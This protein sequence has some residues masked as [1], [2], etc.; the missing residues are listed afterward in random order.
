MHACMGRK[1]DF[2]GVSPIQFYTIMIHASQKHAVMFFED[3][4]SFDSH[5]GHSIRAK[6]L[7][8]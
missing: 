3:L 6:F 5:F 7:Q 4:G 1:G 2:G 8:A